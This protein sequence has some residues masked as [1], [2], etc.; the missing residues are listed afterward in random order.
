[1]NF[2]NIFLVMGI[3]KNSGSIVMK[4]KEGST[5]RVNS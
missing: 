3:E 4:A 5:K 1:M 2:K